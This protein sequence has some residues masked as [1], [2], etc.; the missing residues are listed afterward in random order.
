MIGIPVITVFQPCDVCDVDVCDV[1][2]A[3]VVAK[4]SV[5]SNEAGGR[6][7]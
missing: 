7:T 5:A 6:W 1:C 2:A 4:P 3:I